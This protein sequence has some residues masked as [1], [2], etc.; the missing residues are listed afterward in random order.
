[1]SIDS[2]TLRQ[3]PDFLLLQLGDAGINQPTGLTWHIT[4][5]QAQVLRIDMIE[6]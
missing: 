1:M 3:C 4:D 2:T 6:K 5:P